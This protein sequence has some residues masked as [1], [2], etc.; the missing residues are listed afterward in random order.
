M[1]ADA[2]LFDN[3][4]RYNHPVALALTDALG[5]K[6]QPLP[7]AVEGAADFCKPLFAQLR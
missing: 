7:Y 3:N 5:I 1:L 6:P 2:R 4:R